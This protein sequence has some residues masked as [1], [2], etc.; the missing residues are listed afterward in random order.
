MPPTSCSTIIPQGTCASHRAPR[1]RLG[2]S[3]VPHC[4]ELSD[5]EVNYLSC[6]TIKRTSMSKLLGGYSSIKFYLKFRIKV[7]NTNTIQQLNQVVL[8]Y[9]YYSI[10]DFY[11]NTF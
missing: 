11:V 10:F 1:H 5:V 2:R 8:D 6:W 3:R 7:L 4:T 9:Q